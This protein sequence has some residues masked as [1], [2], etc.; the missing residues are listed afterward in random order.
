MI[1]L[2]V[3]FSGVL[4][5]LSPTILVSIQEPARGLHHALLTRI[6]PDCICYLQMVH[7]IS[8]SI[9]SLETKTPLSIGSER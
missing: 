6:A 3:C 4:T 9:S 8:T 7:L 5:Y 2:P 1:K